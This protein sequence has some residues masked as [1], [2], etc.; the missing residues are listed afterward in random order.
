MPSGW[1]GPPTSPKPALFGTPKT[2]CTEAAHILAG[3]GHGHGHVFNLGHGINQHTPPEH[4][5]I[6]VETV[7]EL[8]RQYHQ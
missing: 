3:Y 6:L 2:I 1:T 8:S 5:E 4:V 7:H